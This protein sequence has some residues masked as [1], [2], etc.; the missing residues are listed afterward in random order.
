ME[1]SLTISS[2]ER[3]AE[4][5]LQDVLQCYQTD[6]SSMLLEFG[7]CA[8]TKHKTKLVGTSANTKMCEQKSE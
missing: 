7:G 2:G 5:M 4:S 6:F 8:K 3:F 1:E